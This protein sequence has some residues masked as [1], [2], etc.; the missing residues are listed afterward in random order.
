MCFIDYAQQKEIAIEIIQW[1]CD[2]EWEFEWCAPLLRGALVLG[3]YDQILQILD[4]IKKSPNKYSEKLL[5]ERLNRVGI[6]IQ[7]L[8]ELKNNFKEIAEK[9]QQNKK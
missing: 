5:I 4:I 9:L 1:C 3:Q 7:S 8:E 6:K 2:H